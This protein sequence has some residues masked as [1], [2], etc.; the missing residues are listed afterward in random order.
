MT[1][2]HTYYASDAGKQFKRMEVVAEPEA[3]PAYAHVGDAGMDLRAA[4]DV[5]VLPAVDANP[6][7]M[8]LYSRDHNNNIVRVR[9]GLKIALPPM[10]VGFIVPRS[11]LG[12]KGLTVANSPGTID[13]GYRG[14]IQVALVNHSRKNFEIKKG[15]R[16]AQLVVVPFTQVDIEVVNEFS[17]ETERGE[18]GFGS[19]GSN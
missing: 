15:D 4:E 1:V 6:F 17:E 18:G 8:S 14:E 10:H 12:S 13:A 2:E 7:G 19:T 9:T 3:I 5:V 11:G 16:I